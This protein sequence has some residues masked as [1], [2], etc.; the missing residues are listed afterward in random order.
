MVKEVT[1][2]LLHIPTD[3][4]ADAHSVCDWCER[5]DIFNKS[6]LKIPG[7]EC[8]NEVLLFL[9]MAKIRGVQVTP[10]KVGF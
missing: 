8:I 4:I 9:S 7:N 10:V 3:R 2:T 6:Y 5:Q 1:Y